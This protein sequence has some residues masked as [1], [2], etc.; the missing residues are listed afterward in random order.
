MD[1]PA[2]KLERATLTAL[3]ILLAEVEVE[4]LR[5]G[6]AGL[7]GPISGLLSI[8]SGTSSFSA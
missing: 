4:I 8:I 1:V 5:R 6:G 3:L 7:A 2:V